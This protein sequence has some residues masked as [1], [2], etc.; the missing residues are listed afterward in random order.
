MYDKAFYLFDMDGTLTFTCSGK[1]CANHF[2]DFFVG[3]NVPQVLAGL[4]KQGS[5][6]GIVTN[7]GGVSHGYMNE[8]A[9]WEIVL[10]LNAILEGMFSLI[11]ISYYHGKGEYKHWFQENNKPIP[12]MAIQALKEFHHRFNGDGGALPYE[13]FALVGNGVT[14]RQVADVVGIDY[15]WAHDFFQWP[16]SWMVEDSYGHMIAPK[17]LAAYRGNCEATGTRIVRPLGDLVI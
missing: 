8:M 3:P 6:F 12:D 16:R 1:V 2:E 17:V 14:D 11:K 9:A 7:Q 5:K 10:E 4:H 13:K 15:Y